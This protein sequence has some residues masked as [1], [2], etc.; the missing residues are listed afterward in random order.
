MVCWVD[1]RAPWGPGTPN[2]WFYS[3]LDNGQEGYLW[4]LQVANQA[5][6]TPRCSTVNWL[7][8][9][10]WAIGHIGLKQP[11]ASDGKTTPTG[12][13]SGFCLTFAGAAWKPWGGLGVATNANSYPNNVWDQYAARRMTHVGTRPPR[14][15]L[16]FWGGNP[17]HIAISLG[18]WEAVGTRGSAGGREPISHYNINGIANYTGWVMPQPTTSQPNPS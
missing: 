10:N 17:W 12:F 1:D 11:L 14:G 13:W 9:S 6:N 16:V 5:T 7:N 18:N 3:I 2:R 8:V 4:S 15:A